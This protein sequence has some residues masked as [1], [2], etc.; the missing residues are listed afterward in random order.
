M[1][2]DWGTAPRADASKVRLRDLL[3]Q[4]ITKGDYLYDFGDCWVHRLT[5]TNVRAGDA[6]L[7]YPRYIGGEQNG[8]PEH[9][10]GLSSFYETLDALTDPEHSTHAEAK[11][12][13]ADYDPHE[14]D[15]LSIKYAL[16]RIANQRNAVKARLAKKKTESATLFH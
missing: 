1:D 10:G 9:C 8:P 11:R 13:L 3:R 12:W 7:A 14:I 6:T 5:I 15:E 2:E 4:P 16:S